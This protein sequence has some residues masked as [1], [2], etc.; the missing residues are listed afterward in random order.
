[1]AVRRGHLGNAI[2][3]AGI[4]LVS[5]PVFGL[6]AAAKSASCEGVGRTIVANS[7]AR[8]YKAN[9]KDGEYMVFACLRRPHR[10]VYLG[11][12]EFEPIGVTTV[13]LRGP[14][15]AYERVNCD[16]S[17]CTGGIRARNLRTGTVRTSPIPAGATLATEIVVSS[18]GAVVWTR[19]L[20]TQIVEV[21]ALGAGGEQLLDSGTDVNPQS[22]A[23]AGSTVYW[24]KAGVAQSAVLP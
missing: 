5:V 1:M 19:T 15:V 8:V 20:Q 16:K 14:S 3:I 7:Q 10:T 24:T 21:R 23:L 11:R 9:F 4:A 13:R 18:G 17:A 22:L 6:T 2:G 12:H